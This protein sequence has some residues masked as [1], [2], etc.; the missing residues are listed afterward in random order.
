LQ[1]A[2]HKQYDQRSSVLLYLH[3]LCKKDGGIRPIAVG[4]TLGRLI[5]KIANLWATTKC[6]DILLPRQ[7]GVGAKG[8]AEAIAHAA[9][10]YLRSS[11]ESKFVVKL[12]FENAFNSMRRD[13]IMEAASSHIPE[14]LTYVTSCYGTTSKIIYGDFCIDSAEGIQQGDPLGPLLF[15]LTLNEHLHNIDCEFV[16]GYLDDVTVGDDVNNIAQSITKFEL[17]TLDVGLKL[18]RP[19]CEVIGL[20]P[21]INSLWEATGLTFQHCLDTEALLLGTPLYRD[22]VDGALLSQCAKLEKATQRLSHLSSHEALYM[23]KHSIAV[24]KLQYLLR[25]APCFLL[26]ETFK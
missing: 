15:S 24:P 4:F 12:D 14:L 11:D 23:L 3:A 8:G 10:C 7:L 19:K 13:A 25:T 5:S 16:A 20:S 6:R 9:R 26:T 2:S 22:G 18:N 17:S 1:E 21:S